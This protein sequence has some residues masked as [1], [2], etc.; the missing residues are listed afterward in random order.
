MKKVIIFLL[1]L[2]CFYVTPSQA[3]DA[4]KVTTTP[5][6][7]GKAAD[8]IWSELIWHPMSELILGQPP[9]ADDFS[10]RFKIAWQENSLFVL[11]EI[12]DDVLFDQHPDPLVNYWDDD[13]LEVFIDEDQSGGDHQFNFNAFAY[14]VAL[15]NQTVD[16]GYLKADKPD[17]LLLNEHIK[18]RW[19]RSA[20]KPNTLVWELAIRVYDKSF[21][22]NDTGFIGQPVTLSAGKKLGFMLAYCDN[23]GSKEREHFIGSHK[24]S[25]V[26]GNKNLGYIDASVF[27]ELNLINAKQE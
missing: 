2:S 6:I 18:S 17:V 25:A 23:D 24:I 19:Q 22:Y 16:I 27:G 12:V 4:L 7:D 10:G 15:D 11:V 1:F 9:S 14:H 13:C 21:T 20:S 26:N 5:I 3:L 8:S